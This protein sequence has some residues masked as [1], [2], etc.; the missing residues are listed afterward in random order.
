MTLGL[1]QGTVELREYNPEWQVLFEV[2]K[3]RLLGEFG[4]RII[5]IEHIGS[6]SIPGLAAKPIID[7]NVAVASLDDIGVFVE[8][9]PQMGYEYIPERRFQDR[10]FFPKGPHEQRTH[11]LNLVEMM[12]ETGWEYPLLFRNYLRANTAAR[13]EYAQLKQGLADRYADNRAS[14]TEAKSDFIRRI[15]QKARR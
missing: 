13:D 11:H 10:Q 3:Q 7:M 8:T 2:E 15:L 1:A 4:D 12:S 14:Y 5:A 9:L 6:T